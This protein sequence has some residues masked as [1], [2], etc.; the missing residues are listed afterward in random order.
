M[1]IASPWHSIIGNA[2]IH[3]FYW[4]TTKDNAMEIVTK[5][6]DC[7][8]FQKQTTKHANPL[9]PIDPSWP[10]TIWGID[11]VG[12]LPMALGGFMFLFIAIDMFTKWMAAMPLV[13]SIHDAAVE[14]L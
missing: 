13:N 10:F 4:P 11:I 1:R 9:Q 3:G 6:R 5:C 2:F 14:F 8:F 12:A 7:Q